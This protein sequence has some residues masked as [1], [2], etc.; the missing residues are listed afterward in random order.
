MT[1]LPPDFL[2]CKKPS[3]EE[4][5]VLLESKVDV[6]RQLLDKILSALN[7]ALDLDLPCPVC[8]KGLEEK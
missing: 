5:L 3:I 1:M 6:L 8:G 4:R 2:V 7:Q